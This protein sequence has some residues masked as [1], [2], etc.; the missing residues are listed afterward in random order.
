MAPMREQRHEDDFNSSERRRRTLWIAIA[1]L[2]VVGV[3]F[4]ATFY[5]GKFD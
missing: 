4:M 5:W 2:L 1:H 3:F